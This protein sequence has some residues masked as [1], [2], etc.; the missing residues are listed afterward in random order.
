ME[1]IGYLGT[2]VGPALT[3]EVVT[4]IVI[5]L[6]VAGGIVVLLLFVRR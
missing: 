6:A 5:G 4:N 3:P 2:Q 1:L